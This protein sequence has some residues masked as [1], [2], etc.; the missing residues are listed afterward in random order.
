MLPDLGVDGPRAPTAY[1][2]PAGAIPVNSTM[3]LL[4]ALASSSPSDIV[5]ANGLYDHSGAFTNPNGHRIYAASPG[6]AVFRAGFSLGG[7]W[8]PGGAL[9]QGLAFDV[10][11]PAKTLNSSIVHVWGTGKNSRLLDL[12]FNGHRALAAAVVVRQPEGFVAQRLVVR[13]FTDFGI[14]VDANQQNLTLAAPSLVEDVDVAGVG[15]GKTSNGTSEACVWLGNSVTLRRARL[16]NCDWMGLWTGTANS[17]SLHEHLDIDATP[18]GVYLEHFTTGSTFQRMRIGTQVTTG[19]LCE[20]ADPAWGSRPG[21]VGDVF[22]DSTIASSRVGVYLDEGTTRTTV[23][24]VVFANQSW[25]AIGNYRGV[26]NT[27]GGNDY[28]SID[29]GAVGVS[30]AHLSS[31]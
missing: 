7:N 17:G 12:S 22:Q 28:S 14:L 19:V 30:D 2:V 10:S 6:G 20:W 4:A 31:P 11:D 8:G 24:R 9:L 21:C 15:R 25:A 29:A 16:R 18:V 5:L 1:S 26:E 27:F 3:G 13:E 23:R